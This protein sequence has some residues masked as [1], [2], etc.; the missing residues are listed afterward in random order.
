MDVL[1]EEN[2]RLRRKI[3]ANVVAKKEK[4][5]KK[6]IVD[7]TVSVLRSRHTYPAFDFESE[8]CH[9]MRFH[10]SLVVGEKCCHP[11]IDDITKTPHLKGL[12]DPDLSWPLILNKDMVV[13]IFYLSSVFFK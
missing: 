6:E 1:E 3:K 8:L 5:K 11:F 2:S 7:N 4:E 10:H 13:E 12:E 9:V